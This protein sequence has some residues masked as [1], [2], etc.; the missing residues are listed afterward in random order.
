MSSCR[1]RI[2]TSREAINDRDESRKPEAEIR[3]WHAALEE[4]TLPHQ[5]FRRR[6]RGSHGF[7]LPLVGPPLILCS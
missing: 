1:G 2:D 4:A 6:F 7:I 5:P 3:I